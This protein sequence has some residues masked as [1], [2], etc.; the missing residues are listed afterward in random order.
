LD[1]EET[2]VGG[3]ADLTQR[4]EVVQST[5]DAEVVG[6]VDGGLGAQCD[7]ELVIIFS[8]RVS[9]GCDLRRPVVDT[10]RR[11]GARV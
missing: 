7:A 6:V 9:Q 8:L 3:E 2:P 11:Q 10:C 4:V 5:A 1:V